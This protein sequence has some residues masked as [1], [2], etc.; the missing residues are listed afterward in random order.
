MLHR[1]S[2]RLSYSRIPGTR[3]QAI[4]AATLLVAFALGCEK[5]PP[6]TTDP[7]MAPWLY[8][9]KSQIEILKNEDAGLRSAAA[10]NLGNM[11]AK[12]AEALPA[13]DKMAKDDPNPRTREKARIAAEKI[14]AETG[15]S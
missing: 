11:G 5:S 3:R 4:V 6:P 10:F 2:F 12:A 9:P 13:L 1:L 14:R 15:G 7:A 8:D